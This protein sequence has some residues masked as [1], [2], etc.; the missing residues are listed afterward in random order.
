MEGSA[1]CPIHRRR[2]VE[3][4]CPTCYNLR[5]CEECKRG[6]VSETDHALDNCKEV[7]Q[8]L[9]HQRSQYADGRQ[10]KE[11]AKGLREALKGLEAGLQH[12]LDTLQPS[13]VQTEEQRKIQRLYSE[14]RY[15]ELYFYTISLPDGGAD[16][17]AV[18]EEPNKRLL[19]VLDTAYEGIEKVRNKIAAGAGETLAEKIAKMEEKLRRLTEALHKSE[20]EQKGLTR[21]LQNSEKERKGLAE[22]LQKSEDEQKRPANILLKSEKGQKSEEE[23]KRPAGILQKDDGPTRNTLEVCYASVR[24]L[25]TAFDVNKAEIYQPLE[26]KMDMLKEQESGFASARAKRDVLS[27]MEKAEVSE[28]RQLLDPKSSEVKECIPEEEEEEKKKP[29]L[30]KK[31]ECAL[32]QLVAE[33]LLA[34]YKKDSEV[35]KAYDNLVS[36]STNAIGMSDSSIGDKAA[37]IIACGLRLSAKVI[38]LDLRGNHIG[39]EGAK[40]LGEALKGHPS[41]QI[42]YLGTA[43]GNT[44]SCIIGYCYNE[45]GNLL[46]D[47]GAKGIA[48]GLKCNKVLGELYVDK[49]KI[50]DVG[51]AAL[52]A[53][54]RK[55]ATALK[56]IRIR[57]NELT[58]TTGEKYGFRSGIEVTY[59]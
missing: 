2:P 50:T 58:D 35:K 56:I 31:E 24:G 25:K 15:A 5:M 20:E 27:G 30:E 29:L 41:L 38:T 37:T 18:M 9:M 4:V 53:A 6:H 45:K 26:P 32:S 49:C 13:L 40:A 39:P 28:F 51:A 33:K 14:G 48:D 44:S 59:E 43:L 16:N 17:E 22:I 47:E 36:N 54:T 46:G 3:Y 52:A 10:A 42:L 21:N 8:R 34:K 55:G 23:H 7:V 57:K 1:C 12:E 19:K 11:L